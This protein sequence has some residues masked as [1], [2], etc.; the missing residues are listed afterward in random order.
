M[1]GSAVQSS[2]QNDINIKLPSGA[3]GIYVT[4]KRLFELA[5]EAKQN[6]TKSN[7]DWSYLQLI[8]QEFKGS[9]MMSQGQLQE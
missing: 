8:K 3:L 9:P 2:V 1:K 6:R 7:C 4:F 5:T